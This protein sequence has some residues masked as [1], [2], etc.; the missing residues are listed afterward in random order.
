M[1]LFGEIKCQ[2]KRH[3]QD[4][5][6]TRRDALARP[7]LAPD[8]PRKE[9]LGDTGLRREPILTPPLGGQERGQLCSG[10]FG[11]AVVPAHES[12]LLSRERLVKY[13]CPTNLLSAERGF[14]ADANGERFAAWFARQLARREWSPADFHRQTGVST[15]L[16]SDW[17]KSRKRPGPASCRRIADAFGVDLDF[18]LVLAGHREATEPLGPDDEKVRIISLVKRLD[19]GRDDRAGTLEDIMRRWLENDRRERKE[20][21]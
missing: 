5:R 19:L 21:P 2:K 14:V 11:G 1:T 18:V 6:D 12:I 20:A 9:G 3:M 10:V 13:P 4:R 8:Q 15:G 7:L 16:I 17:L